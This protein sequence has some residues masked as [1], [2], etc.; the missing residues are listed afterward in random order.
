[1]TLRISRNMTFL[2]MSYRHAEYV[3]LLSDHGNI[4][5]GVRLTRKSERQGKQENEERSE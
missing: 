4:Q 1:M 2:S 5:Q 3:Y